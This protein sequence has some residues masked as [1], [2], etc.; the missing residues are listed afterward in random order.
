MTAPS[1][2]ALNSRNTKPR[3]GLF[4]AFAVAIAA[5]VAGCAQLP[6]PI[7]PDRA[8]DMKATSEFPTVAPSGAALSSESAP[9]PAGNGTSTAPRSERLFQT[10]LPPP[11]RRSSAGSVP[12]P[13][14]QG[15]DPILETAVVL[16]QLPLPVFIDTVF[17]TILK[18]NVSVDPSIAQRRELVS[19]RTGRPQNAEG[20]FQAARAVL[21]SYD[22]AVTEY[23]GL[24]RITP[25]GSPTGYAPEIRRGRSLPDVPASL[26]PVFQL[27]ELESVS[28]GSIVTWLR[29]VFGQRV[30]VQDDVSRQAVLISGQSDDVAAALEA[31]QV[32][33][34][35]TMRGRSS[36]RIA[37]L[38]WS[39]DEMARRL[40]EVLQ[41][42]GYAV[43]TNSAAQTPLIVLPIG[44]LNS[45]I[46]FA[47]SEAVLNHALRWA[48]ELDQPASGR[49]TAGYFTYPVRNLDAAILAK[50]LQEVLSP[51]APSAAGASPS[52]RSRVVVN[53]ATN[54]LI[55]QGSSSEYQQWFGLLQELDRPA[56]TALVTVT[57]AEVRL[58]NSE[59]LGFEWLLNQFMAGGYTVGASTL[60]SFG[61]AGIGGLAAT[62]TS[63]TSPA[64]ALLNAL[65][66]TARVRVLANPSV[67]A[68]NGESAFIQVGDEVPIVTSQ[69]TTGATSTVPG[70]ATANNIIQNI[71]YRNTGIV[72]R[73]KPV[74]HAGGRIDLDVEQEV[75][76]ASATRTGVSASPTI[77]TRKISTK[78]S[79]SDGATVL[80]GGLMQE[81]TTVSN[82][83]IPLLKDIPYAGYLFK[84]TSEERVRTELVVL[85]TPYIVAD[86]FEAVAITDAFRRQFRWDA[87]SPTQTLPR[88]QRE[89]P[90]ATQPRL[91]EAPPAGKP[92]VLPPLDASP[93]PEERDSR[94]AAGAPAGPRAPQ[95]L[96][97]TTPSGA[98]PPVAPKSA[99]P[100][101]PGSGTRS[102][103]ASPNEDAQILKELNELL[104]PKR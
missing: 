75:S 74:I 5:S 9:P 72:L 41:A 85:I 51:S 47:S 61:T 53:A 43:G 23:S 33:D 4:T 81:T 37:P 67:M 34:Q 73:V 54:T 90:L 48:T 49:G 69:Q 101:G 3:P 91:E 39:A 14:L 103:P 30:A 63:N 6:P 58:N 82:T 59:Q 38:F 64:R 95:P 40:S 50:T 77:A 36:A 88:S 78:L 10:P 18:R 20:L 94:G 83:G 31:I 8:A 22:I 60:G 57:I 104:K 99:I 56:R 92:Y 80:L 19:L 46:V 96:P 15:G 16:D 26:R 27:V 29:T 24:I 97:G 87:N 32:L 52:P 76:S 70:G 1:Q 86:E 42:Q 98:A 62:I 11:P 44:P 21:K 35:P 102:G 89:V 25:A 84:S 55:I 65:A 66:S 28:P 93:P 79:L 2:I 68:R 12:V 7:L 13:A 100:A 17:A 71:Q 45:V